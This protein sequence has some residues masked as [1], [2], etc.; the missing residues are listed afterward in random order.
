MP[1]N[2]KQKLDAFFEDGYKYVKYATTIKEEDYANRYCVYWYRYVPD[3][4]DSEERFM[5]RG[6]QRLTKFKDFHRITKE[7]KDKK[8]IDVKNYGL[9]SKSITVNGKKYYDKYLDL[10]ED[11]ITRVLDINTAE[12]KYCV[13]IFYNHTMYK[14]DSIVFTNINPPQDELASD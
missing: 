6:W 7:N 9:P 5:S 3:Y 13:I 2:N 11:T 4:Y 10:N 12:E 1:S 8:D 14:S